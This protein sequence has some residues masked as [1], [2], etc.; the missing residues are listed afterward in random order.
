MISF[1]LALFVFPSIKIVLRQFLVKPSLLLRRKDPPGSRHFRRSLIKVAVFMAQCSSRWVCSPTLTTPKTISCSALNVVVC[2]KT[3]Q[4]TEETRDIIKSDGSA[5]P[6]LVTGD[7]TTERIWYATKCL[8]IQTIQGSQRNAFTVHLQI[9]NTVRAVPE[10]GSLVTTTAI[11]TN[12][13]AL[14]KRLWNKLAS[15]NEDNRDHSWTRI[16]DG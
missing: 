4:T 15:A 11:D 1:T 5:T 10:T 3:K 2:L 7:S 9:V 8:F 6:S 16:Q 13:V 12:R 14:T